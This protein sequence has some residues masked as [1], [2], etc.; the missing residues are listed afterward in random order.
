MSRFDSTLQTIR[1]PRLPHPV[2]NSAATYAARRAGADAILLQNFGP[3]RRERVPKA[4][5]MVHDAIYARR[6]DDFT[7]LERQ[8]LRLIRPSL[9]NADAVITVSRTE[10]RQLREL[11]IVRGPIPLWPIYHGV[12]AGI[13]GSSSGGNRNAPEY[14][15]LGRLTSRKRPDLALRA[16]AHPS[17]PSQAVLHFAGPDGNASEACR[18]LTTELGLNERVRFHGELSDHE[19]NRLASRCTALLF[20]SEDEGFGLPIIEGMASGLPVIASDIPTHREIAA[21]AALLV[22]LDPAAI[23]DAMTAVLLTDI[24][25]TLIDRGQVRAGRFTW[26]AAAQHLLQKVTSM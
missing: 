5:V 8:Y 9:R 2:W 15:V 3:C 17:A 1:L 26:E 12:Q 19:L 16:L 22:P 13:L 24:R 11:K 21:D 18:R 23:G 4:I 20:L 25:T 14:L 7:F 6:P 10:A